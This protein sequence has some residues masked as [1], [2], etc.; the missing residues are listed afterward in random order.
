MLLQIKK[1]DAL[2]IREDLVRKNKVL[3]QEQK[4]LVVLGKEIIDQKNALFEEVDALKTAKL[5]LLTL[6]YPDENEFKPSLLKKLITPRFHS[7]KR[8][9][10]NIKNPRTFELYLQYPQKYEAQINNLIESVEY[11]LG[12]TRLSKIGNRLKYEKKDNSGRYWFADYV[13]HSPPNRIVAVIKLKSQK[14]PLKILF[15]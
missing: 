10:H 3:K 8:A 9:W 7:V 5:E 12:D 11:D 15:L 2:R 4:D 6:L 13:G 14:S 1:I